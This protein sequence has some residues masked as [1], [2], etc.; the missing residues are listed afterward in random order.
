MSGWHLYWRY[1]SASIRSQLQ[2]KVS[3]V[4]AA[5]G[6]LVATGIEIS[7][8]WA[9]FTRFGSLE[10]WDLAQVCLFYGTVNIAFG[11]ADALSTGFD[12]FGNEYIRTGNFDR[13]LVRPRSTI[14][15]LLG[16]EFALRRIGRLSTGIIVFTWAWIELELQFT[17]TTVGLSLFSV[18]GAACLFIGLLVAQATLAFWTVESLEI[19]NTMT[20]GGVETAQ[21]PITIYNDWFRGFFTFVVPLAC[22]SYFP[23]VGVLGIEDPLGTSFWVQAVV[24][25][26]GVVFL[27]VT[28]TVFQRVGVMH[29]TSTGN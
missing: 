11:I 26:A 5:F 10:H 13:L 24:P 6:Q 20:Y 29:Y 22:V 18:V 27:A 9:L 23:L 28:L 19:M 15:Q 4:L 2:Y 3:F 8:V 25:V 14:L 17:A 1:V 7:G 21:Y 16:H 12:A